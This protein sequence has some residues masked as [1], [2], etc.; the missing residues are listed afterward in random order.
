[1]KERKEWKE[2]REGQREGGT[3]ERK[4]REINLLLS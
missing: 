2:G 4:K 1:M 3:K